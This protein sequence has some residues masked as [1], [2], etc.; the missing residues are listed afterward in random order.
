[1]RGRRDR[2]PAR[3]RE[4]TRRRARIAA[5]RRG[6]PP[7]ALAR[8]RSPP[9]TT[10]PP[11]TPPRPRAARAEKARKEFPRPAAGPLRP[12]VSGQTVKYNMKK[13]AGRGFTL[14]ELKEAG[15]PA[16]LAPTVGIAV[17]H[18]RRNRSLES[19]QENAARLKAYKANL[20]VFPRRAGKPKAGD[21]PAEA[22]AAATQHKGALLPYTKAAPAVETVK[23]TAEMKAAQSYATLRL[24]RMNA[25]LQGMRK[26]RAA[27]AAAAEK[28]AAA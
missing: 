1:V 13:R 12:I 20:V 10:A 14:A 9:L 22:L 18:R 6:R 7:G 2:D 26:K 28:D 27:E 4:E 16:K 5:R 21:A 19:L 3:T 25:R 15:I 23:V 17:D 8:P 24:E 11:S